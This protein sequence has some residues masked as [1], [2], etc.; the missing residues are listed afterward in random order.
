ME[1]TAYVIL[2]LVAIAWIIAMI[3][4][5]VAAF[6]AGLIGLAAIFA[7]GLLFVKALRDRAGQSR[8]DRYS[9]DVQK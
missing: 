1:K 6:P 9:R 8:D 4:G 7:L 3:A 5:M 2:I